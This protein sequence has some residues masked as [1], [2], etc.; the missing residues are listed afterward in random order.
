M[1]YNFIL[2]LLFLFKLG[3]CQDKSD[4]LLM[5]INDL[6][7][8]SF[9]ITTNYI[10]NLTLSVNAKRLVDLKDNR[11]L[12]ELI[13]NL[14][15]SDKTVAIHIILTQIIEPNNNTFAYHYEYGSDS[16]I[17]SI[18]YS[19]NGLTWYCQNKINRNYIKC[20]DISLIKKYWINK[21]TKDTK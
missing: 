12:Q 3:Y 21:T 7:W 15:D 2:G 8:T 14:K 4:S 17:N 18:K 9:N 10:S 6:N 13:K 11:K 5:Y 1:K 20:N 19:Y 16:T